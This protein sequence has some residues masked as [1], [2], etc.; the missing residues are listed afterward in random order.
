MEQMKGHNLE[1]LRFWAS[2]GLFESL[3]D[4]MSHGV[5]EAPCLLASLL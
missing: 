3:G 2:Q 5:G 1:K 4:K